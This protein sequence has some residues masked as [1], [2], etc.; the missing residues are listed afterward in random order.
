MVAKLSRTF[1]C[2]LLL[3]FA[4]ACFATNPVVQLDTD[5]GPITVELY[6]E[7]APL[8]V[9]NFLQY[10]E[11]GFYN[12]TIFH[13]VIPGFMIQGGGLTFDFVE[14][15]TRDPVRNEADNGLK[16]TAG[17]LA[18]ARTADPDSASAQFY[19][20]VVDNPHLDDARFTVFGQVLDGWEVIDEI[21]ELPRGQYSAYPHAPNEMVRILEA[22]VV[23]G[24][25]V[26]GEGAP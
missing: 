15:E 19:I 8:T 13:R 1:A 21:L 12:G 18:M 2:A 7:K 16:N 3:I 10:V 14:K 24:T 6:P 25:V 22:T 4:N 5:L 20:N 17:S 11:D 9:E 26:E 23:E